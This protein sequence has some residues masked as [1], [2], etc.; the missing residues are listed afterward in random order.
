MD[1]EINGR[2]DDAFIHLLL[3][4]F[5][6][7][8]E[9]AD[10]QRTCLIWWKNRGTAVLRPSDDLSW[11][12]C[13]AIVQAHAKR[14]RGSPW[15][16][17][18][19]AYSDGKKKYATLSPR[20]KT[21]SS[22]DK[23]RL[24]EQDRAQAIDTL[25]TGLDYRF[26]GALG[27]PSYWSSKSAKSDVG[28]SQWDMTPRNGGQEF[29]AGRLIPLAEAV[30]KRDIS[31]IIGGLLGT[32]IT[33]EIDT[34]KKQTNDES[35]KF[36]ANGL[37]S[38][39]ITDNVRAWCALFGFSAFPV[40]KSTTSGRGD[41]TAAFG[42]IAGR[43]PFVVLPIWLKPWTLDRYRAVARSNALVIIGIGADEGMDLIA[44]ESKQDI[45]IRSGSTLATMKQSK[46]WLKNK[47][48]ECCMLF[49]QYKELVKA[50]NVWLM[51]GH[52]VFLENTAI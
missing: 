2:Y 19:G 47:G 46:K 9:D 30:C 38:P 50:P 40:M 17:A 51:K 44:S 37:R 13:A 25:Q 24:L 3:V 22:P 7:L 41:I 27:E 34:L 35:K 33:D 4:G 10:D 15:L 42:Q 20:F 39:S 1:L 21:P 6:S 29:I 26:I 28:A 8:L 14:W 36:T 45:H 48:V 11:E 49:Q 23:W 18:S 16:N 31:Q 5:A 32:T 52:P 43:D 12:D